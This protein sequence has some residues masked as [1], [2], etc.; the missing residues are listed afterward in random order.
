VK[1]RWKLNEVILNEKLITLHMNGFLPMVN[2]L[3]DAIN[4]QARI[5]V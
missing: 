2:A 5:A 3:C 1:E 4:V